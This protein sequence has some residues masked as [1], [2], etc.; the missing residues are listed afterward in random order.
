[1]NKTAIVTGV[2]GQDGSYL[3]DLLLEKGYRV[4]GLK[5][6]TS[7]NELGCCAHLENE[8]DFEI[9]E[10]DITDLSSL[11]SLCHLAQADEFYNLA[12]QSHVGSS[13]K[14][15]IYTAEASG[16][17]VLNCLEAIRNSGY[18]T[19]FY[20]ASTSELYGGQRGE[21]FCSEG[22]AFHPRSPYGC[23][24]MYGYSITVNYREAYK[25]FTCNGILF[26]HE[27][28]RRG[29]N[30][31]TRKITL[32]VAAIAAGKQDKLYLGN[33]DSKRDWGHAKD[34]VRGMYMMLNHHQPGDYVLATGET[35]SVREF[36]QIAF[37]VAGL[38]D[39]SQYVEVDPRFYRPAEVD[40]LLGDATKAK[41]VFG[42]EPEY[43]FQDLVR[44]MV[45]QD[46]QLMKE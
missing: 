3:S 35:H 10:G 11:Q 46:M 28:P 4:F 38:E 43:A 25:M 32:G 40:I 36:C 17:A 26:N 14:Q 29:P 24:K 19:R 2:T 23:A 9:V 15:P 1:M 31:V 34:Y 21:F 37:E 33:L 13:F 41:Q 22:T 42:W 27:S 20:Q 30:F 39:Y 6:R 45:E 44:E 7:G 18:H 8:P 16:I 5:R 12:S